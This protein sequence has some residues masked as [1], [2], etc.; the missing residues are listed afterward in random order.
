[1]H[2]L[3]DTNE[4]G[5]ACN[6]IQE[7]HISSFDILHHGFTLY[8][9]RTVHNSLGHRHAHFDS[10]GAIY[11]HEITDQGITFLYEAKAEDLVEWVP[12]R[13]DQNCVY[14]P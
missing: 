4:W 3:I 12:Y 11:K 5:K 14:R 7:I 10:R 13:T 6:L 1:M 8:V 9:L 2:E